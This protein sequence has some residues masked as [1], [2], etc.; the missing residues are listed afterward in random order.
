MASFCHFP[1]CSRGD[2]HQDREAG[3]AGLVPK[4]NATSPTR[5]GAGLL[6]S[7]SKETGTNITIQYLEKIQYQPGKPFL[8][9]LGCIWGPPFAPMVPTPD[10]PLHP[11]TALC[12]WHAPSWKHLYS[13]NLPVFL[14][15]QAL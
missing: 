2:L 13:R 14:S 5:V 4:G 9:G 15:C 3:R 7:G 11:T 1:I 10:T 6:T 8:S 12:N